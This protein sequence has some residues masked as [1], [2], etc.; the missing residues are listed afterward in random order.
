ME[1]VGLAWSGRLVVLALEVG[2]H[3]SAEATDFVSQ[4]A[5]AKT[6]KPFL[7]RQRMEQAC[8][9]GQV[10]QLEQRRAPSASLLGLHGGRGAN[11]FAAR[12]HEVECD[13][14]F[15]GLSVCCGVVTSS[16]EFLFFCEKRTS[17]CTKITP[18]GVPVSVGSSYAG[19]S[20]GKHCVHLC[21]SVT[22]LNMLSLHHSASSRTFLSSDSV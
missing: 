7:V 12:S 13:H 6:R 10:S 8:C 3:W 18:A 14:R 2:G 22:F 20:N 21:F 19:L 11:G 15:A 17:V 4:L 5:K 16:F 9:D 1:Q